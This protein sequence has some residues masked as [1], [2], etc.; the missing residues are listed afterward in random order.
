LDAKYLYYLGMSHLKAD[1]KLESQEALGQA[2]AAG[3]A[4]PLASEARRGLAE[5]EKGVN[6]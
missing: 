1:E 2:L 4:D 3:L 6:E 5:L